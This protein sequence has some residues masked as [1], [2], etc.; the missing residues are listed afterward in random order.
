MSFENTAST[1]LNCFIIK[2][3]KFVFIISLVRIT[4]EPTSTKRAKYV[5][6]LFIRAETHIIVNLYKTVYIGFISN[7]L[8]VTNKVYK[9]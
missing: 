9:K 5:I 8:F 1:T 4:L 7:N 2:T 3:F 6:L